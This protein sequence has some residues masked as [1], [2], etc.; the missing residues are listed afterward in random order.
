MKATQTIASAVAIVISLLG[1]GAVSA[2]SDNVQVFRAGLASSIVDSVEADVRVF[3]GAGDVQAIGNVT[4][5]VRDDATPQVVTAGSKV[6]L[7]DHATKRLTT[8]RL[9]KTLQVSEYVIAC[10]SRNL[11]R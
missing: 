2:A 4:A 9:R 3:R 10:Q 6:W 5:S 8:C 1:A 7:V 11:P